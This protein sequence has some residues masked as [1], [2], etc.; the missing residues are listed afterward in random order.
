MNLYLYGHEHVTQPSYPLV[1]S[2]EGLL[3]EIKQMEAFMIRQGLFGLAAPQVG[4]LKQLVLVRLG[5]TTF[6]SLINP[7]IKG[8]YGAEYEERERC[9]SCPPYDN[10]CR[11][12]RIQIIEVWHSCVQQLDY[13]EKARFKG[14]IARI[15]QHEI[16]HLEGTFFFHRASIREKNKV[17]ERFSQWQKQKLTQEKRIKHGDDTSSLRNSTQAKSSKADICPV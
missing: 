15:I 4:I 17:I 3:R 7:V 12:S 16:D 11:V 5:A 13:T 14:E 6:L 1:E 9:I 2:A 8:M 10:S